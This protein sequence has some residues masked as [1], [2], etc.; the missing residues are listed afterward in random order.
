[1]GIGNREHQH[2]EREKKKHPEGESISAT[3]DSN[4]YQLVPE[5]QPLHP[6]TSSLT[7][8]DGLPSQAV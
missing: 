1:M 6:V 4:S 7:P 5:L 2:R 3:F 8:Y